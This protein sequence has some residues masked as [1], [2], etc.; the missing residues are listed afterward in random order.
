MQKEFIRGGAQIIE[1]NNFSLSL[2]ISVSLY[3]GGV[4]VS[5][6]HGIAPFT[7]FSDI[8]IKYA[9]ISNLEGVSLR[10]V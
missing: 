8:A 10:I 5:D 3:G 7:V 6:E 1:N 2:S 4:S 9:I